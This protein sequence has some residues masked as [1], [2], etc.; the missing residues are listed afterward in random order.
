MTLTD[1]AERRFTLDSNILVYAFDRTEEVRHQLAVEIV[2]RAVAADCLLTLQA[3][4]EFYAVTTRKQMLSPAEA[5]AQVADWLAAF[6]HATISAS[7]ML[8]ALGHATTGRASYWDALLVATAAEAG[9]CVVL[10][11]DIS[12]GGRFGDIQVHN[13]FAPGGRLTERA[14]QLLEP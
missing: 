9:C 4:S 13:P 5:A 6:R 10:S 14:R 3:L 12:D 7:A 8:A 11:E 1:T 2:D